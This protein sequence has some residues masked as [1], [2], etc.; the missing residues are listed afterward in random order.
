[1]KFQI[2]RLL[3][4]HIARTFL[5]LMAGVLSLG[6]AEKA[7][8]RMR[9][10]SGE[11]SSASLTLPVEAERDYVIKLRVRTEGSFVMTAKASTAVR[12]MRN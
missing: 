4:N 6:A 5:I 12:R 3:R 7:P 1:M 9:A 8:S 10:A 11:S 2:L